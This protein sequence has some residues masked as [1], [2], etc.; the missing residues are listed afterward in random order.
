MVSRI[1]IINTS[2]QTVWQFTGFLTSLAAQMVK[3][4]TVIRENKK[5]VAQ[6]Y[7]TLCD[8]MD[9][10]PPMSSVHGILQARIL[11]WVAISFSNAEDH[12]SIT[13]SGKFPGEG[14]G[15][16]LQYSCLNGQRSQAG[17]NPWVPRSWTQLSN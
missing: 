1:I 2:T 16:P 8:P 3:N 14:H 10:S 12:G 7:P 11:E 9:C 5:K 13:G 15:N 6:S 17:Y 4:L